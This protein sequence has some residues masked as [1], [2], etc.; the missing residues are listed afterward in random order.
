MSET[1]KLFVYGSLKKGYHN[2]FL[3]EEA[4]FLG[5][6]TIK[7]TMYSLNHFPGVVLKGESEI[8]GELYEVDD[9]TLNLVDRLEGYIEG[10]DENS[11][12]IRKKVNGMYVYEINKSVVS[13]LTPIYKDKISW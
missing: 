13:N 2:H 9:K 6:K 4:K 3:L 10:D 8:E 7:G 11:L 12:Y 5:K 1:Y